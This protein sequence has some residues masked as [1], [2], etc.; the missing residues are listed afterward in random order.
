MKRSLLISLKEKLMSRSSK[1][2]GCFETSGPGT[3]GRVEFSIS[4][5]K[6]FIN[7]LKKNGFQ[8][9]NDEETVQ[10]FFLTARIAPENLLDTDDT[11]NPAATP[12]LTNEANR[13]VR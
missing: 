2:W 10:L 5:N 1:P 11:V 12:N 13:F 6:A 8:G 7:V 4:C 9:T 3:D